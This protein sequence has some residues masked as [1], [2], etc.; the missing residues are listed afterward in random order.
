M[1]TPQQRI[2]ELKTRQ[3]YYGSSMV[4]KLRKVEGVFHY[5]VL[6]WIDQGKTENKS[7]LH[8][9]VY[10]DSDPEDLFK[11]VQSEIGKYKLGKPVNGSHKERTN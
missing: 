11:Y 10:N 2:H 8:T 5:D 1:T 9:G 6:Q 3:I 4:C 7:I